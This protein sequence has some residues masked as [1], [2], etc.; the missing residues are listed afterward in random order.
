MFC[1]PE[2]ETE[3][4]RQECKIL[5]SLFSLD[6]DETDK[7]AIRIL[8]KTSF[9]KLKGYLHGKAELPTKMS[10]SAGFDED[11]IYNSSNYHTIYHLEHHVGTCD[12]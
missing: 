1:S 2:C 7:L 9:E 4:H 8:V 3:A 5:P 6:I 12:K 10:D 11:G